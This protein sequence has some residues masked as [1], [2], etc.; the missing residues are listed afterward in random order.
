MA[1]TTLL[2]ITGPTAIGKTGLAV[3]LA[4]QLNT[5]IL[6]ADS[7]QFF[8]EMSIGTAKPTQE[9]LLAATHYF[10]NNKSI[11]DDYDAGQYENEAIGLLATLFKTNRVILLCGGSGMY[12]DAVC[13]GFDPIPG[14]DQAQRET[15]NQLFKDQG[16]TALQQLLLANDPG[17]YQNIDLQNPH[18]LIRALEVTLGSGTP[19]SD[20]RKGAGTKRDFNIVK[21]GLNTDRETLYEQINTRVDAMMEQ[22][23]L[24]EASLLLPFRTLNALQTV[25]YKELFSYLDGRITLSDAVAQIKQNTRRFAKRQLTWFRK[26][27]AITWFDPRKEE[28]LAEKILE[29]VDE[30]RDN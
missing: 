29:K 9:E 5:P 6:S 25:G 7:R 12:L 1:P 18:R 11:H 3:Q 26:D 24:E 13:N 17:H 2:V 27:A 4:K 16:I 10:I 28:H 23:L 22:G 14:V 19:Y 30:A 8:R 21:I 15:L 20:F